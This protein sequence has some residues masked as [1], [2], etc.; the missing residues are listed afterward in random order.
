MVCARLHIIK[1][2]WRR[3]KKGESKGAQGP[4]RE[5]LGR[6]KILGSSGKRTACK[7]LSTRVGHY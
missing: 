2:L 6:L 5:T 7:T 3:M 1:K 4:L